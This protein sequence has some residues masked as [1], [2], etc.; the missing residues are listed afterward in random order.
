M[1]HE[2]FDAQLIGAALQSIEQPIHSTTEVLVRQ[3][4]RTELRFPAPVWQKL[5]GQRI[6]IK[7]DYPPVSDRAINRITI[8]KFAGIDRD[9]I[10]G[11]RIHRTAATPRWLCSMHDLSHPNSS[12]E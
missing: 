1:C 5:A 7:V 10:A 3:R 6:W 9:D 12:W 4:R 8:M 11:A 2:F